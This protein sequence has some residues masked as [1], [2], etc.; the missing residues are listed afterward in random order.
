MMAEREQFLKGIRA[1]MFNSS[2]IKLLFADG[3]EM[4]VGLTIKKTGISDTELI[5]LNVMRIAEVDAAKWETDSSDQS[6]FRVEREA[7]IEGLP[8]RREKDS[9]EALKW[10]SSILMSKGWSVD[11]ITEILIKDFPN[12][13]ISKSIGTMPKDQYN[14]L[15]ARLRSSISDHYPGSISADKRRK[16]IKDW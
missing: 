3:G 6:P 15:F 14:L 16:P 13:Q 1:E 12:I 11:R 2:T 5:A 10:A 7:V 9:R 4:K 8:E